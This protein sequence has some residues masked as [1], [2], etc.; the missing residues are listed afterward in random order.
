MGSPIVQQ[1]SELDTAISIFIWEKE[2][3]MRLHAYGS[4]N[5]AYKSDEQ[6]L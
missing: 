4:W 6:R 2:S 5:L 1:T 3:G